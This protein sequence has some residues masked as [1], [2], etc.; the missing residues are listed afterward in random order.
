MSRN[1]CVTYNLLCSI[2]TEIKLEVR[3]D[4]KGR[5]GF[6][7]IRNITAASTVGSS[8]RA[9]LRQQTSQNPYAFSG[10]QEIFGSNS[11]IILLTF[12]LKR[13]GKRSS[14]ELPALDLTTCENLKFDIRKFDIINI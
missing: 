1:I 10:T 7:E 9:E 8:E 6:I 12:L 4:F 14:V 2:K 3:V 11:L 13:K 5:S